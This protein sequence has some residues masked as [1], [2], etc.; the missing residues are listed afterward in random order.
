MLAFV[1]LPFQRAGGSNAYARTLFLLTGGEL[2]WNIESN[3]LTENTG[4]LNV[5]GELSDAR[6]HRQGSK[7]VYKAVGNEWGVRW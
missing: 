3:D 4:T 5:P 6:G 1:R 2:R 7:A